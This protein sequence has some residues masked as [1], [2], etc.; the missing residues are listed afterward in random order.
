MFLVIFQIRKKTE[1]LFFFAAIDYVQINMSYPRARGDLSIL[2][3]QYVVGA[4]NCLN[5]SYN[6]TGENV[7]RLNV[8]IVGQDST[9]SLLWR[10]AGNQSN[11]WKSG[12][13]PIDVAEGF[14]VSNDGKT[15]LLQMQCHGAASWGILPFLKKTKLQNLYLFTK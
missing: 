4:V 9:E 6:M 2:E 15:H 10:L 11:E 12:Q 1:I 3:S 14:K 5:F 8:Y 13:V 7:G